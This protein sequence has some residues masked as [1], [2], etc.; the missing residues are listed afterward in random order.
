[1][2]LTLF[3]GAEL[4]QNDHVPQLKL[5]EQLIRE[6]NATQV[7]HIPFGRS[8]DTEAARG[9]DRFTQVVDLGD[10]TYLNAKHET[11]IAQVDHPLVIIT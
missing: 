3:G 11:D 9:E 4:D 10:K 6:D 1:M 2:H 7:F 8:A 5:I